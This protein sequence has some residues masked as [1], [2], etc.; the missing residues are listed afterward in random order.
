MRRNLLELEGDRATSGF[1]GDEESLYQFSVRYDSSWPSV[2]ETI[3]GPA[4]FT[5]ALW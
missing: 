5:R 4:S 2:A 3:L 1:H